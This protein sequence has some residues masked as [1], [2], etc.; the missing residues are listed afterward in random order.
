MEVA[1]PLPSGRSSTKHSRT[2]SGTPAWLT[3][4]LGLGRGKGSKPKERPSSPPINPF[5][6]DPVEV[7]RAASQAAFDAEIQTKGKPRTGE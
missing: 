4:P 2:A 6:S 3:P 1:T 5:D 7:V